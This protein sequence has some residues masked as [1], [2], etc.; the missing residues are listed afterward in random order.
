MV[1]VLVSGSRDWKDVKTVARVLSKL[2]KDTVIIHGDAPG[3]DTIAGT[4]AK[5]MGLTVEAYPADWSIGRRGG[6]LRNSEMLTKDIDFVIAFRTKM[7]SKGTND[8]IFKA[9]VRGLQVIK[10]NAW[11]G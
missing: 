7:N 8:C 4:V 5:N 9:T 6:L 3:L 11:E 2:P 1:R 10:I